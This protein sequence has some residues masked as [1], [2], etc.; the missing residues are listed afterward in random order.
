MSKRKP[1]RDVLRYSEVP[2]GRAIVKRYYKTYR[3][4]AEIPYRCDMADCQFHTGELV[5][6]GKPLPLT[7]D[8]I[9]GCSSNNMP[10]NL[11]MVCP[12]CDAQLDTHGGRNAG[13]I[14]HKA[15]EGYFVVER[16]KTDQHAKVFQELKLSQSLSCEV[17][18]SDGTTTKY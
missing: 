4:S 15:K 7:M 8:H 5:W 14:R 2:I 1:G 12:N 3:A 13:R 9:D 6:K 16:G 17:V 10:W 18:R 11:R